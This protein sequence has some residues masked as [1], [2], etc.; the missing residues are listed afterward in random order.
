M[1]KEITVKA[2]TVRNLGIDEIT[3]SPPNGVS[4]VN[5]AINM[6][7]TFSVEGTY[8]ASYSSTSGTAC[9]FDFTGGNLSITQGEV[10]DD[11]LAANIAIT[12]T[13]T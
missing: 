10:T 4:P 13:L 11:S 7:K 8:H 1:G 2:V 3:I 12:A 5:L 9:S 6:D